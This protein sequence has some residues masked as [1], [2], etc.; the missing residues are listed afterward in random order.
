MSNQELTISQAIDLICE[1]KKISREVVLLAIE[2]ALAAAYRRDYG[3]KLQNIKVDFNP[4]D[5]SMKV[6]DVKTVV[7]DVPLEELEPKEPIAEKEETET[8]KTKKVKKTKKAG[9][10][11]EL[12]QE[13]ASSENEDSA[14]EKKRFNPKTDIQF[15]DAKKID[16][17]TKVGEI[18]TSEL[19]MPSGFGRVAAQT[20]KQVI[21]QKIREAERQ[22]VF[23]RYKAQEGAVL[24][25]IIQRF[26]RGMVMV[27]LPDAVA[28]MPGSEQIMGERYMPNQKFK[29]YLQA[30]RQ[31]LK[32]LE[33]IVS[34]RH[35][36]IL[37]E[38]F[39]QEI[40]EIN[41]GSVEIK[42]VAREAGSRAKVAVW[43]SEKGVDP[44][45]ACIGQRGVRIQ[46]IISELGGEKIDIIEWNDDIKKFLINS[47]SPAKVVSLEIDETNKKAVVKARPDQLSLAIGR[48]G[49]NVRLASRLTGYEIDVQQAEA[50]ESETVVPT[51]QPSVPSADL[52]T[53]DFGEGVEPI[54]KIE[55]KSAPV[56]P[57]AIV[58]KST[59]KVRIKK[60]KKEK[61][62]EE[63]RK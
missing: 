9:R 32:G 34:R 53:K 33:I 7:E 2:Q 26:D 17:K 39:R 61:T 44:V 5:G 21:V 11:K 37:R 35:P 29:F 18:V 13:I 12:T 59:K 52:R 45:G 62:E 10:E 3:D 42:G 14:E 16:K 1:E 54:E 24:N 31:G 4:V 6:Y 63:S 58:E 41:S 20:A 19:P 55:E 23:D 8:K 51:E 47:L 40:P 60:T 22:T 25:G 50:A 56:T 27:E 48:A 46:T 57:E 15:S 30:V 38:L 49:Q 28:I 43:T 36:E